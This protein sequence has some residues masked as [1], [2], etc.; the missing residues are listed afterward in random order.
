M[1]PTASKVTADHLRRDAYLYVRQSSMHQVVENTEST[2][3][4]YAL[5]NRAVALGWPM[6]RVRVIDSDLG[7]SAASVVDRAGF[8]KLVGE[9]GVGRA[10]INLLYIPSR[11]GENLL[12]AKFHRAH[13]RQDPISAIRCVRPR[14]GGDGRGSTGHCRC[15][16]GRIEWAYCLGGEK[17]SERNE[18]RHRGDSCRPENTCRC[19]RTFCR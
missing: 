13:K 8:Q 6:E 12:V 16:N 9:V 14:Y 4:Q 7:Q 15:R 19:G 5:R 18:V 17:R 11:E 2:K 1:N 10:E 3:R